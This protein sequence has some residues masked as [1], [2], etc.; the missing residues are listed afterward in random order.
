MVTQTILAQVEAGRLL[1]ATEGLVTSAYRITPTAQTDTEIRGVVANGD[2]Q[3]YGVVLTEGRAFCS[4]PDSIFRHSIC[5]HAVVLALHVIRAPKTEAAEE[6]RPVN[7]K[8]A[9]TR[10]GWSSCA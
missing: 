9:K 8:L 10:P 7:L 1:K 3:Q 5:K 2:G 6:P 4:C